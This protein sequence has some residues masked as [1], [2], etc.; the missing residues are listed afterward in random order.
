M[1]SS[2]EYNNETTGRCERVL[3]T[4]LGDLG[5]W[6][7]R[8]FLVGGLAPR[9]LVRRLPDGVS[10]H[11]GTTDIDLVIGLAL[12]DQTPE[13]YRTLQT[14]L[15]NSGFSKGLSSFQWERRV[16]GAKVVVE[17]LCETDKVLP[18]NIFRPSGE[19]TG[20]NLGAF[21][22]R[23][24]QLTTNDFVEREVTADRLDGGGQ[25]TVVLRVANVLSYTVLKIFAFQ[26]R[27]ENKD[28]Y[29]L[30]F[31]L[32]NYEGG[33]FLAGQAAAKSGVAMHPIVTEAMHLLEERFADVKQD[34]P[35]AYALFVSTRSD[36][37]ALLR[38]HA[39]ATVKEFLRGMGCPS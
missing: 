37:E 20:S 1:K 33:P 8:V 29:D 19:S 35:A 22:V 23:G 36:E 27:H 26:D 15:S 28:S 14:N 7:E 9:Y 25:S 39:V 34:G 18:G 32:G 11:I 17:F 2:A 10:P 6:R 12:G 5:P 3:V 31:T 21:N 30:I 16:D 13:T 38:R 4:L 24:A